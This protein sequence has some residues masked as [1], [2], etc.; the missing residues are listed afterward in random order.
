MNPIIHF[1]DVRYCYGEVCAVENVH[2]QIQRNTMT[3]LIGPNGGG[4]STLI[5]LLTGLIKPGKGTVEHQNDTV[6]GYVPQYSGFD[7]DF[8]ITVGQMILSGTLDHKIK[9]FYRYTKAQK[10]RATIAIDKVG[11]QGFEDRGIHQLSGGQRKRVVIARAL[12]AKANVIVLDEPDSSLDA[13]STQDL[14]Q[15]LNQ[16]KNDQTIVIASHHLQNILDITDAAIYINR[17]AQYYANPVDLKH[18]LK[19]GLVL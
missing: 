6:I 15:L 17:S 8:P 10:Q 7:Q 13:Q 14:Y 11:L 2:F 18:R 1:N 19:D 5:K 3:A 16:L 9:P 4:K 12:A